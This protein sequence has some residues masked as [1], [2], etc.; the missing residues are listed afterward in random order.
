MDETNAFALE[1]IKELEKKFKNAC[2]NKVAEAY[3]DCALLIK[4]KIMK[5]QK[6]KTTWCYKNIMNI[7]QQ[8]VLFKKFYVTCVVKKQPKWIYFVFAFRK[9]N[10]NEN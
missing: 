4:H 1:I 3:L 10:S 6:N 9:V 8:F 7:Y 5:R 2:C